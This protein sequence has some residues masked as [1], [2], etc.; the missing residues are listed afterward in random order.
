MLEPFSPAGAR[1][2]AVDASVC[3]TTR[4]LTVHGELD[5]AVVAELDAAVGAALRHHSETVVVDLSG[6]EFIDSSGVRCLL[7]AQRQAEARRVRLVVCRAP[8]HVQRVF[9]LCGLETRLPFVGQ[10]AA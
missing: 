8:E 5:L 9:A 7:R 1:L 6:I 3:G 2:F 10:P 4:T